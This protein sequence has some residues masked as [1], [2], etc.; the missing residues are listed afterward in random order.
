[1]SAD[2]AGGKECQIFDIYDDHAM[3]ASAAQLTVSL[4]NRAG[5]TPRVAVLP[6]V[7]RGGRQWQAQAGS[8]SWL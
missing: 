4:N 5:I 1:M 8:S 3:N 2:S 7:W 6:G